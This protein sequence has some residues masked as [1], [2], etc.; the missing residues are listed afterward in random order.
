MKVEHN[1]LEEKSVARENNLLSAV[2]RCRPRF[3]DVQ[4]RQEEIYNLTYNNSATDRKREEF[5]AQMRRNIR[6]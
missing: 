2:S 3:L 5:G 4:G 1:S 6:K